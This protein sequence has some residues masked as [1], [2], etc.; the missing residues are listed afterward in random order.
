M[1]FTPYAQFA[2]LQANSS[3]HHQFTTAKFAQ[4]ITTTNGQV[5]IFFLLRNLT[6]VKEVHFCEKHSVLFKK[7][8]FKTN[9]INFS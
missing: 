7:K 5:S 1:N 3:L 4:N 8:K 6:K 9:I 2:G